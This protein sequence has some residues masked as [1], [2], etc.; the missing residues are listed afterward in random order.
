MLPKQSLEDS[1]GPAD[2]AVAIVA[3]VL[4]VVDVLFGAP[5]AWI[6]VGVVTVL[7]GWW[8]FAVPFWKRAH[9]EQDNLH[10]E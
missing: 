4:L 7:Y 2:K 3:S 5:Q 1:L 6:A 10:E 8:W 9:N